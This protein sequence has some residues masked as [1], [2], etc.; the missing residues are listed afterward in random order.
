MRQPREFKFSV[1]PSLLNYAYQNPGEFCYI[2]YLS[3]LLFPLYLALRRASFNNTMKSYVVE[4]RRKS[5]HF[6][7]IRAFLNGFVRAALNI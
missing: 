6:I 7:D 2:F 4:L 5:T 3:L 1:Q